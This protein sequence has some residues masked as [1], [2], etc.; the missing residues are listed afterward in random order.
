M[1]Y[2][3]EIVIVTPTY[4]RKHTLSRLYQSLKGQSKKDFVWLIVDDGSNDGT[5]EYV[6]T[7]I[8]D[9]LFKIIY[10]YQENGGKGRALNKA[11]SLYKNACIFVIVDSDDY[12]LNNAIEIIESYIIKYKDMHEIGAFFFYYKTKD[13]R[14]LKPKGNI[15]NEDKI[16][17]RYEYNNKYIQND[18]CV[19]YFGKVVKKYKYPEFEGEKYIAPTIIQME[20]SK[21]YKIVFLL[22]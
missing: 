6:E 4:N 19:C 21:E 11:F 10:V 22:R 18:G 1:D 3:N 12:L 5:K 15:I 17:T 13:G 14:L 8:K 20:M 7:I 9:N 16:L 2:D